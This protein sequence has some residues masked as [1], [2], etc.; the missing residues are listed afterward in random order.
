MSFAASAAERVFEF[1]PTEGQELT[2]ENGIPYLLL[3]GEKFFVGAALEE[4]DG[5]RGWIA[6]VISNSST[7]PVTVLDNVLAAES[8]TKPLKIYNYDSLKAE[9]TRAARMRK[10]GAALTA[11]LR[12]YTAGGGLGAGSQRYPEAQDRADEENR[13]LK[14]SINQQTAA[15]KGD[16]QS[17]VLR[18][19]T[20]NP[21]ES[22]GGSLQFDLPKKNKKDPAVVR[23]T[24]TVAG[25]VFTF[26]LREQFP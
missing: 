7:T 18:T 5:K 23:M 9:L 17:R 2:Y 25:E 19:H 21:G 1:V 11:G 22:V 14:S 6:L 3:R 24:A 15:A 20:V 8:N 10:F 4:N 16:I 12:S 13:Q 26:E